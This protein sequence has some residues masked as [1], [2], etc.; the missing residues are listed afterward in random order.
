MA[1]K[2]FIELPQQDALTSGVID[3]DIAGVKILLKSRRIGSVGDVFKLIATDPA[4]LK[5]A[6]GYDPQPTDFFTLD[7]LTSTR[8]VDLSDL[9]KAGE[10][11]LT[12]ESDIKQDVIVITK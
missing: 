5:V 11:Y 1:K 10:V 6:F 7:A 2:D 9:I 8:S 12:L 3:V 4:T